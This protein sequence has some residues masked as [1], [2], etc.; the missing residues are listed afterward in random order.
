MKRVLALMLTIA[1][2]A[3]AAE[4]VTLA[5]GFS[6]S[7]HH[8]ALVDGRVRLYSEAGEKNYIE[9]APGE[10][11]GFETVPDSVADAEPAPAMK[12]AALASAG[13]GDWH[14]AMATAGHAR[15]ID[16]ALLASVVQAESGGNPQ[17]KSRV[18]AQGLMQLMPKT[19]NDLG[20]TDNYEPEQNVR[21][22]ATY[23]DALLTRYHDDLPLAL[24]AYNA[25]PAA[26]DRYHGIPPYHET[27]AYVARVIREF[28]KRVR[29]RE[30]VARRG[31]Q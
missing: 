9:F 17:A 15:N 1:A 29:E 12:T 4:R 21:G 30:M 16:V 19:A 20:V 7:C 6:M 28:N 8:H 23:L 18:G 13:G 31:G 14:E 3:F 27:R 10:I 26:V 5:N 22:G 24:A 2:P 11:A 25:G